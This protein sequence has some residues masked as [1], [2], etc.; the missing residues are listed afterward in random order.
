MGAVNVSPQCISKPTKSGPSI[1]QTD[2]VIIELDEGLL[3]HNPINNR[4]S[5][6]SLPISKREQLTI[7]QKN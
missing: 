2:H 4:P 7:Q 6:R 1:W 3:F 5:N